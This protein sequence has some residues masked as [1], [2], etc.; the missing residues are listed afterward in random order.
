[1]SESGIRVLDAEGKEVVLYDPHPHQQKAH[2]CLAPNLLCLG[3]RGTGKSLWLR[4]DAIIRCLLIPNFK[5]LIVRR[6]MPELRRSHLGIIPHEMKML[7]G[8]FLSTINIAKF[9]NG[10]TLTF[11]HCESEADILNY[12][13]SEYGFIGFDE[14]STFSLTQFSQI[15][16][17]ARAPLDAPYAAVVRA[18]SN[19]LGV[20]ADWMYAWFVD[21]TV[22][23]EDFPDYHPDDFEM[24]FSSLADNPSL[25]QKAYTSR[26]QNL[27]D[28]VRRA[29]LL[30]ERVITGMYFD[31]F[32]KSRFN[33]AT[34]TVEEWHVLNNMPTVKDKQLVGQNWISVYRAIDWGY[35]PDPAV[36]LW[37]AVLPNKTAICFKER[38]WTRTLAKDVAKQIKAESAGMHIVDTFCDPSMFIKT[39][40]AMYSIGDQFEQNGVACTPCQNNRELYGYSIHNYLNT[41]IDEKPQLQIVKDL[42]MYGCPKLI[43]TIPTMRMDPADPRKIANGNDHYVVALAYFCMGQAM[44]QQQSA[45]DELPRWMRPKY[46][47]RSY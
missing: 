36:C 46:P 45:V 4:W 41:I 35:W 29:W 5:A 33:Q 32:Q 3:T 22:R 7:G 47:A 21:K 18:G 37:I 42:G 30:G 20:G 6:T 25:D 23:L 14:L 2:S 31:D 39:G 38:T 44:P 11:G 19:P 12:L 13:S 43:E 34:D 9:P 16:A 8:V 17:A 10:S 26:L 27:P 1:M 15:S 40:E 24:Q 28:H